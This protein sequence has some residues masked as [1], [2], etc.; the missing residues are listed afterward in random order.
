[1]RTDRQTAADSEKVLKIVKMSKSRTL[2][3][4]FTYNIL[5][6]FFLILN[7]GPQGKN[8]RLK[9]ETKLLGDFL[10]ETQ[11]LLASSEVFFNR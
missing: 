2:F 1:M 8:F 3:N 5:R 11:T 7:G 6:Y 10:S 4:P 9:I